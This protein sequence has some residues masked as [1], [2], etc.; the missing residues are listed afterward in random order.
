M[1]DN[2]NTAAPAP[3][4]AAPAA[5]ESTSAL[6]K[7]DAPEDP[8]KTLSFKEQHELKVKQA[9]EP[10]PEEPEAKKAK[11]EPDASTTQLLSVLHTEG[12]TP[13]KVEQVLSAAGGKDGE[14][15]KSP[16]LRSL[17]KELAKMSQE[18]KQLESVMGDLLKEK[19]DKM[20][21]VWE[22][23]IRNWVADLPTEDLAVKAQFEQGI[24]K[25]CETSADKSGVW[26]VACCASELHRNQV[27]EIE[28][29]RQV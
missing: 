17:L 4:A 23:S 25:L 11:T 27:N 8:S 16:A 19:T 20:K 28:R 3:A 29:L 24:Q 5:T 14:D 13:E 15:L 2:N 18:K 26:Q 21:N 22:S 1:A 9:H 7:R 6:G 12:M 10:K